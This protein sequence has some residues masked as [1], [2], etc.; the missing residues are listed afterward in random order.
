MEAQGREKNRQ[1]KQ[2]RMPGGMTMMPK[3]PN[4]PVDPENEEFVVFVRSAKI[5]QWVPA[6]M[7]KGS[8]AANTLVK[9]M[10]SQ[11]LSKDTL[12]RNIGESVYSNKKELMKGAAKSQPMLRMATEVQFGFKVRNKGKPEEW[13]RPVDIII[14]P[15]EGQLPKAPLSEVGDTV[16]KVKEGFQNMFRR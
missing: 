16:D 5:G 9:S 6:T 3:I 12:I 2:G 7:V 8:A 10:D 14:L 15:P 13:Y 1:P 4:P 11:Q